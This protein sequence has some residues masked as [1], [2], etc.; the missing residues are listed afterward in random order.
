MHDGLDPHLHFAPDSDGL[1][2]RVR[3]AT[4]GG[5]AIFLAETRGARLGTCR[6][7]GCDRAFVDLGRNATRRYYSTRCG[8]TDA[9]A[10]HRARLQS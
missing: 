5:L 1:A 10:R 2:S 9:V 8:N 6:R 3:A 7:I 4:A